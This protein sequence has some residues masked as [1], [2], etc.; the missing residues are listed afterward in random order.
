MRG[1]LGE[2]VLAVVVFFASGELLARALGVVDRLNGYERVLYQRGPSL[3]LPYRLRP[4]VSTVLFG[5]PIRVNGLGFRG[6]EID[7][8]PPPGVTRVLVL[9]D[10]VVFGQEMP[11][12]DTV[13]GVLAQRLNA[14]GRGRFETVNAG[15]PGYDTVAEV[16]LLKAAGLALAPRIVV[17]GTSLNDYDVAPMYNPLGVLTRKDLDAREI[18]LADRSEF[19]MLLRFV[20]GYATGQLGFQLLEKAERAHEGEPPDRPFRV[21][22]AERDVETD[23]L[24]FYHDPVP[25]YWNRQRAAFAELAAIARGHDLTLLV[26]IFP[27]AYQVEKP[28]PD[29]TPQRRLLA[30]CDDLAIRCL[31]LQPA[32]VAAGGELFHDVLHPNARGHAI[33]GAAIAAALA[34]ATPPPPRPF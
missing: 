5:S 32:F 31:D 8:S 14:A 17:V 3:D 33:A 20:V 26:A 25:A 21:P 4:G 23:R 13:S 28:A 29:L 2:I 7:P 27:E 9:G 1:R 6:R 16:E 11:D 18:G 15:V 34:A 24:R 22:V 10:S 19:L 12:D 30:L